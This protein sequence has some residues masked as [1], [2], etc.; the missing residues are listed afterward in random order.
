MELESVGPRAREQDTL[1]TWLSAP[2]GSVVLLRGPRGV[3]KDHLA[4]RLIRHAHGL[5]KTVVVEARAVA[6]PGRSF[7][8]Y[9]EITHQVM[10][11]AEQHG[12]ADEL[13]EPV[14]S[15]LCPVLEQ[16]PADGTDRPSE[17]SLPG[18]PTAAEAGHRFFDGFRLLLSRLSGWVRPLIVIRDLE[19]ADHDTLA[20]TSYLAGE[21]F[22]DPDLDPDA[23]RPGMLL[24]LTRDESSTPPLARDVLKE[25]ADDRSTKTVDLRSLDLEG[26]RRYLQSSHVL[27]RLLEAS[28]GLPQ[29]LE[30][31][32][33]ALPTNVEELVL[34]RAARLDALA[35]DILRALTVSD[36]PTAS[37]TLARALQQPVRAVAQALQQLRDAHLVDRRIINGELLYAIARRR[38]L[39]V[40]DG[41][42]SEHDRRRLHHR[43]AEA[44]A[45]DVDACGPAI[46]A[47][48]QLRSSEPQRGVTLAVRAAELYA[49]GGAV[50]AA[51]E[52]LESALPH[53]SPDLRLIISERLIDLA[54]QVGAPSR[55]LRHIE[56]L[57][58]LG[59]DNE[60]GQ[61]FL[62]EAILRNRAGDHELALTAVEHA[63]S[64]IGPHEPTARAA[65]E[66]AA[67]EAYYHRTALDRAADA[68]HTGLRWLERAS[69]PAPVEQAALLTQLGK[70]ALA[71]GDH[72][73]ALEHY[74]ANLAFAERTALPN[75]LAMALTN[76]AV[77]H[78]RR[79]EPD[80]AERFLTR[81][82]TT[83]RAQGDLP[84]IAFARLTAGALHHQRGQLGP[85]LAAY[86]ECRSLFRRLGN[87]TQL[88]T[89]LYNL[90]VIY[91]QCGD[92]ARATA[93]NDEAR[94]LAD[95][96]GAN[97]IVALATVAD[98][99]L[100][101]ELGGV[102]AG[103]AR[104]REGLRL[105]TGE[106]ADRPIEAMLELAEFQLQWR[107]TSAA[108]DTMREVE[109]GLDHHD[110]A[111]LRARADLIRGRIGVATHDPGAIE[112]LTRARE[113][114]A[115]LDRQLLVRDAEIAL[116]RAALD[117]GQREACRLRLSTA[118]AI[119]DTVATTLPADLVAAFR[120]SSPQREIAGLQ[121]AVESGAAAPRLETGG[122][123]AEA[124]PRQP[125]WNKRYGAIVGESPRLLR[126]FHVLDRIVDSDDPVL[127]QGESGTGKELVA[128]A[129]HRGSCRSG[130]PF[131]KLNCAALVESLLLSELFGH[132][133]G[134]FTGAHQR[135]IG[136]FEMARGGT[137]FLDE[138][139]DIS[140]KT[141]VSLLRVLQEREFERVGGSQTIQV[142]AR[143]VFA[144]NRD[145]ERMVKE[146]N[147]REDLYYRLKGISVELPP[148]R[149]RPEDIRRLA[150]HF[151]RRYAAE[152]DSVAKTLSDAALARL[153]GYGW[154]GNVRE[155]EN[156]VR[157]VALFAEGPVIESRDL[158]EYGPLFEVSTSNAERENGH[159]IHPL[160]NSV[161][162][163]PTEVHGNDT[164]QPRESDPR[165]V[166]DMQGEL[167]MAIFEQGVPLPELKKRL[168]DQAIA[169]ALTLTHGNITRAAEVLGMRRPRLSQIINASQTLKSLAQ[170]VTK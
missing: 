2:R 142:D 123:H 167:L 137:L 16:R 162:A 59:P 13:V 46:L 41:T 95:M 49:V 79:G 57:K 131:V 105:Q 99:G 158:D 109:R 31:I 18:R 24:L 7:Q 113:E 58:T 6:A 84:T 92:F 32:F 30:A 63:R 60:R 148:L 51:V 23:D 8:P 139:G 85:A 35:Q 155:L 40:I 56:T 94:R 43:W 93:N 27:R 127:I 26:V 100:L 55:A 5:P 118:R 12:I 61:A 68:A 122:H 157:S 119:Q 74:Q 154:P 44:L 19:Q 9:A 14:Y 168:Q 98:G 134:A 48:H 53:A 78:L 96:S 45:D 11:W 62:K 160:L 70:I 144:T 67:S 156:I 20:L 3:G 130:A 161:A 89:A 166:E 42:L 169:R 75:L 152:S 73:A 114:F 33:D 90:G 136:R 97:R 87:R 164:D 71:S 140:P 120:A 125:E 133:R 112:T 132:E 107:T 1:E 101:A 17:R 146:G 38:D 65:V 159:H 111:I 163:R 36:R 10:Q 22:R 83:A 170:G 108:T 143:I 82:I 64:M 91:R 135:K 147:F 88:A 150:D 15:A 165:T 28:D 81:S 21:L 110:A 116:A 80:K 66:V 149:A 4:D 77:A 153:S 151:L 72:A 34:R 121:A 128:E 29:E 52:M 102:D 54:P 69:D 106:S 138:V 86:G 50:H 47:Y 115:K 141:Q 129:I 103:E 145:L 104:L 39:E 25:I 124:H 117:D 126:V 76:L 37:R